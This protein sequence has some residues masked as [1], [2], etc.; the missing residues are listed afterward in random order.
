MDLPS[1]GHRTFPQQPSSALS[2]PSRAAAAQAC[3]LV[4]FSSSS[5]SQRKNK[6][7]NMNEL[8]PRSDCG[9]IFVAFAFKG[10]IDYNL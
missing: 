10:G 9:K 4:F 8:L 2:E 3:A 6:R 7:F 1:L 5:F